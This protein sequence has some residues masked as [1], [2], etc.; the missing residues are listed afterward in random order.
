MELSPTLHNSHLSQ[1]A[2]KRVEDVP[3]ALELQ[4]VLWPLALLA[5]GG[6][7]GDLCGG[8]GPAG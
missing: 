7:L 4:E 5:A 1:C 8:G 6:Q 2:L 3:E